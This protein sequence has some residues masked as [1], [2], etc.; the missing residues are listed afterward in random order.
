MPTVEEKAAFAERLKFA[1]K[2]APEKLRGGTDLALHFNLRHHGAHP[3]SPQTVH[4]WLSRPHD[5]DRRQAA[6]ARRLVQGRRALAALWAAAGGRVVVSGS[7]T[8]RPV[9]RRLTD[10]LTASRTG[11]KKPPGGNRAAFCI[12][13]VVRLRRLSLRP[14]PSSA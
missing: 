5:P 14:D 1:M 3:V 8:G 2:R 7:G 10:R 9:L 4:K 11:E 13:F 6:D 12:S